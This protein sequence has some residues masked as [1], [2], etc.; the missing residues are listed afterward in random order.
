MEPEDV[1][2]NANDRIAD[3]AAEL[4]WRDPIPF[5]CECSDSRCFARLELTLDEYGFVRADS[6]QYLMKP[7]HKLAGGVILAQDERVAI[8]EKLYAQHGS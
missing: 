3:K 2:R 4:T 5:L 7:G 8:G 1:F 6:K